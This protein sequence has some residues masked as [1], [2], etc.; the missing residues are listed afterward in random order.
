MTV[1]M[2]R[3][4]LYVNVMMDM[5]WKM[6]LNHVNGLMHVMRDEDYSVHQDIV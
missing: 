1:M 2:S 3:K 4:D 5:F 6:I